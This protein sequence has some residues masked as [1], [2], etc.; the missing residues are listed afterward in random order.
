MSPAASPGTLRRHADQL[1]PSA[2]TPRTARAVPSHDSALTAWRPR[3]PRS[4]RSSPSPSR[5][6]SWPASCRA[7]WASKSRPASPTVLA[8]RG[9]VAEHGGCSAGGRLDR[10]Q[11]ETLDRRRAHH[12]QRPGVKAGQR[13]VADE[14]RQPH[15]LVQAQPLDPLPQPRHE[16]AGVTSIQRADEHKWGHIAT[17]SQPGVGIEE[18]LDVLAGTDPAHVEDVAPAGKSQVSELTL[19]LCRRTRR[20]RRI[21]SLAHDR[22]AGGIEPEALCHLVPRHS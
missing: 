5:R 14:A 20:E 12:G 15:V 4:A 13:V 1:R 19:N 17:R 18:H 7:E 6:V 16:R 2:I 9:D 10:R 22:D 11:P 8:V 21:G 3:A